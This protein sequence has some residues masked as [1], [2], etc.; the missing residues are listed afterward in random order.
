MTYPD[1]TVYPFATRNIKEYFNIMD[2]YLDTTLYPS[3]DKFAFLQE[4]W[5]YDLK[6]INDKIKIKGI[7]YNEMKGVY[8]DPTS[9]AWNMLFKNLMPD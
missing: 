2:I 7:V 8:S 6:N 5:R 1:K 9:Q 3:I 4:G